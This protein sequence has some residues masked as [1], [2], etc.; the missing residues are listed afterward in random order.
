MRSAL[1]LLPLLGG[2]ATLKPPERL[3]TMR[4]Q[5][6]FAAGAASVR[7][8]GIIVTPVVA[9][10]MIAERRYVYVTAADPL[11]L[12]Q[13]AT[14]FWDV[15]P[16]ASVGRAITDALR[17]RFAGMDG[18]PVVGRLAMRL[19]RF[20]EVTGGGGA[21]AVVEVEATFAGAAGQD[22]PVSG[23]YCRATPIVADGSD[24][25][26]AAFQAGVAALAL[27]VADDVAAGRLTASSC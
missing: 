8:G 16:S 2:C 24:A 4:L 21:Q 10:G 25:R 12:R 15:P 11:L 19:V 5:P 26:A 18:G 7:P 23:R 14:L 9:T 3:D 6:R 27:A 22:G 1:W 13:A 17:T 20:E